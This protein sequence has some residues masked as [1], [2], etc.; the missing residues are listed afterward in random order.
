MV[1]IVLLMVFFQY[2]G[3]L[4][5]DITY[6]PM[7]DK[8][9]SD[10]TLYKNQFVYVDDKAVLSNAW[11]GKLYSRHNLPTAKLVCGATDFVFMISD[12]RSLAYVKDS[13]PI[14]TGNLNGDKVLEI[15]YNEESAHFLILA[16][17]TL[18]SF[19]PENNELRPVYKGS[20]L[21]CFEILKNGKGFIIGTSEGYVELDASGK[22][23]RGRCIKN[24]HG[25]N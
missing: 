4:E 2:P 7:A 6:R 13:E 24:C 8:R 11:A 25:W 16:E 1:Y 18:Y 9:I 21:T 3:T 12:G 5:P 10:M 22:T 17:K 15:K 20:H 19:T 14:W 23:K